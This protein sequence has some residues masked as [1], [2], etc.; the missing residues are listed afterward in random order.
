MSLD[1]GYVTADYL[2]QVAE[3]LRDFKQLSYRHMAIEAGDRV[4]DL[5]CGPAVD[6]LP[7]AALVGEEGRVIG[8]DSDTDMLRE[9]DGAACSSPYHER[10]EHRQG[11]AT[12]LPLAD[13][14]VASCRAERL[15][16]VL[17][18]TLEQTIS[19]EMVRVTR[20]GGRVVLVDT[21]W[22]SASVDF[23]DSR[24]ERRLMEFFALHMRPNGFAGRHLPALCREQ[25]LEDIR[26]D[27]VPMVQRH[28]S[29]TPFGE[30]LLET[31]KDEGAINER[32]A[33]HWSDE[34][35]EREKQQ[36]FYACVN[37]VIASGRKGVA[38]SDWPD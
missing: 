31:A 34:L 16:Q 35:L 24:L 8:I 23:S 32:E 37:M 11:C 6:T 36:R 4:L 14:C 3:R 15:L 20:P 27:L 19:K 29:E 21:D 18:Q 7:L 12:E 2:K 38:S 9:A 10:I 28:L 33:A 13:A 5:G 30:W 1:N 26:V 25:A 17:P 22:G